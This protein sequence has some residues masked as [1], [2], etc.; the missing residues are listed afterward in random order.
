MKSNKTLASA[1]FCFL[2]CAKAKAEAKKQER[3]TNVCL[4]LSL[5]LSFYFYFYILFYYLQLFLRALPDSN[6][7]LY[8]KVLVFKTSAINQ[9][10]PSTPCLLTCP[11]CLNFNTI[12]CR[13]YPFF[14]FFVFCFIYWY[15]TL[16][17]VFSF[18]PSTKQ[19]SN[20]KPRA[21]GNNQP[22]LAF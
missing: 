1:S 10:R 12:F 11:I 4:S 17:F 2:P 21:E 3:G 16:F 15:K 22:N 8:F 7:R 20:R 13:G 19:D 18:S 9:T 5:S 6:R 14:S